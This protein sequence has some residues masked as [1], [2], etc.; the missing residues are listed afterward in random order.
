MHLMVL[1]MKYCLKNAKV[2]TIKIVMINV[3]VATKIL[4]D[5]MINRNLILH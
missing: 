3:I 4:G 2:W 5:S 1:K